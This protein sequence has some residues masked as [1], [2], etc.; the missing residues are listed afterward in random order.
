MKEPVF[1][2]LVKKIIIYFFLL[3]SLIGTGVSADIYPINDNNYGPLLGARTEGQW[4]QENGLYIKQ[5]NQQNVLIEGTNKYLNFGILSGT[6][7]Y[8]IRDNS[9]TMEFKNN[10]G[11]WAGF[12]TGTGSGGGISDPFTHTTNYGQS[13]SATTTPIWQQNGSMT[14]GTAH[15]V[16]TSSTLSTIFGTSWIN[17]GIINGTGGN[18]Y[19][20]FIAQSSNPTSPP[21]GTARFHSATTQG[22]T[23]F[24]LD[25]EAGTNIVLGRD[26]VVI[27]KNTSGVTINKGETVYVTGSTG[28]VPNI[29]K[30]QANSSATLH[31][32]YVAVDDIGINNFGQVMRNGIISNFNTSAFSSGASVWVSTSTAGGYTSIRPSGSD[33]VQRIGTILVSGVGNGSID[34]EIAP[35][36]LNMETGTNQTTWT[37]QNLLPSANNTYNLGSFGSAYKDIFSSSTFYTNHILATDGGEF[38]GNVNVTGTLYAKNINNIAGGAMTISNE[39]ANQALTL[40]PASG[41]YILFNGNSRQLV[42]QFL[43]YGSTITTADSAIVGMNTQTND[44]TLAITL[45]TGT[46]TMLFM[47]NGDTAIN[48]AVPVQTDP[49]MVFLPST[50]GAGNNQRLHISQGTA[51]SSMKAFGVPFNFESASS[52]KF[53]N[54]KTPGRGF[55]I[56]NENNIT[57]TTDDMVFASSTPGGAGPVVRT[58]QMATAID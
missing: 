35:A 57:S 18:G 38:G 53:F 15:F 41:G 49:T 14:S 21:A 31:S 6:T 23:R 44:N 24:E 58:A 16:N 52:T 48:Y 45:G 5:N 4:V 2:I 22:F 26:S 40:D 11:S 46:R 43:Y 27:A 54:P 8:G 20:D 29:A 37:A 30:A 19:L 17:N 56:M 47:E 12:G 51:S 50:L 10:A 34:V 55:S 9:G 7:G 32:I 28:N 33:Y 39:A 3:Y 13:V 1:N 36:I 25:N 42:N